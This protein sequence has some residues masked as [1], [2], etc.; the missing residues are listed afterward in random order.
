[1]GELKRFL[2]NIEITVNESIVLVQSEIDE[3]FKEHLNNPLVN[4][5]VAIVVEKILLT[6]IK[7]LAKFNEPTNIDCTK[8]IAP[9]WVNNPIVHSLSLNL[10][11][12]NT[13]IQEIKIDTFNARS[14]N[15][16]APP[17]NTNVI[18]NNKTRKAIK[19]L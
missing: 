11:V 17:V 18:S 3:L 13:L 8:K 2:K 4:N 9:I 19:I 14:N 10:C 6:E 16:R 5:N 7:L 1:M 15:T 12:N